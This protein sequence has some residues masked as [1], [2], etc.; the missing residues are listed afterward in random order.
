MLPERDRPV[1]FR[2]HL[3]LAAGVDEIG[4]TPSVARSVTAAA[5]TRFLSREASGF[6]RI[7]RTP[8]DATWEGSSTWMISVC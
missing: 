2:L 4:R 8:G 5:W 3:D 1:L 7:S 6:D